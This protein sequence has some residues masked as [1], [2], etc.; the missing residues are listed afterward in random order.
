MKHSTPKQWQ[1]KSRRPAL[2]LEVLIGL[3]LV[4]LCVIPLVRPHILAYQAQWQFVRELER[5]QFADQFFVQQWQDLFERK[6]SW[7]SIE[8]EERF[9]LPHSPRGYRG[10]FFYSIERSKG[11][12]PSEEG[13]QKYH[14]ILLTLRLHPHQSSLPKKAYERRLFLELEGESG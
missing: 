11:G 2:L 12:E 3:A 8:K 7:R 14:K 6:I 10:E 1:L 9:P 5:E 13:P 4:G